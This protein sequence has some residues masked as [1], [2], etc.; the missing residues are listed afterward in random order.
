MSV[1]PVRIYG[2]PILLRKAR[3]LE[4][5]ADRELASVL[6]SDLFETMA[7]NGGVGLAANQTG[8]E[9]SVAVIH[10]PPKEGPGVKMVLVNPEVVSSSGSQEG[11]EGCLSFPGLFLRIKRADRIKVRAID[12]RGLPVELNAEGFLARAMQH[13]IDHLNGKVFIDRLSMLG[14]LKLK[15]ELARLK[16]EWKKKNE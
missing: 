7:A 5:P 15:P 11:M 9:E 13:E 10:I 3:R 14:R 4:F 6:I 8:R 12:Q 2:D 16:K 1:L